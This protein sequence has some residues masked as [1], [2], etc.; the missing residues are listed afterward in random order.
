MWV[1]PACKPDLGQGPPIC[2]LWFK[3][4]VIHVSCVRASAA[5]ARFYNVLRI[6]RLPAAKAHLCPWDRVVK[7][8]TLTQNISYCPDLQIQVSITGVSIHKKLGA[9]PITVTTHSL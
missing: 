5:S 8:T 1:K 9:L 4:P 7:E 6:P 2:N 3:L